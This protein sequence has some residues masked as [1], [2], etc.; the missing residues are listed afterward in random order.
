[1]TLDALAT[2]R[3]AG[4]MIANGLPATVVDENNVYGLDVKVRV[5]EFAERSVSVVPLPG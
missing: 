4:D 1:M 5:R 2:A 3:L